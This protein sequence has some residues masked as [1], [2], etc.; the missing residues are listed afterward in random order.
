MAFN[1]CSR[2]VGKHYV[3]GLGCCRIQNILKMSFNCRLGSKSMLSTLTRFPATLSTANY[4]QAA[5]G[6]PKISFKKFEA[7]KDEHHDIR[8]ARLKRPMSPHLTIYAPQ[9]TSMLSITHRAA[10][11]YFTFFLTCIYLHYLHILTPSVDARSNGTV[12]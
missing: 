3:I 1:M 10:G 5:A 7:P 12:S 11:M 2:L 9:L 6:V 8:N 4:A